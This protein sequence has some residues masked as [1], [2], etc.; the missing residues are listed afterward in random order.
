MFI[1]ILEKRK[2]KYNGVITIVKSLGTGTCLQVNGLTQ[3]GG[4]VRTV[5]KTV[6]KKVYRENK[7]I[8]KVLVLGLGG[9]SVADLVINIWSSVKI[10]G[11]EID[12]AMV[13]MGKKYL[14]LNTE[15][16]DVIVADANKWL[17]TNSQKL[18][19]NFD[20]VLVDMYIGH[21]VPREFE[22][23][24]FVL[25]IRKLLSKSG[26]VV[27]NRLYFGEKR[28]LAMKFSKKLEKIFSGVEYV[29]PEANLMFVCR[30]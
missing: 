21:D 28:T 4:V 18:K 6:L 19:S 1:K 15:K 16:V 30:R 8:K 27:F 13:E 10:I 7:D 9:G 24:E 2:S 5:W 22:T 14:G 29:Y 12:P 20:L 17:K 25:S 3:S 26:V 23:Q 11:V